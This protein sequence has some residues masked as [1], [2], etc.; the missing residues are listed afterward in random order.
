[1][2]VHPVGVSLGLFLS[3]FPVCYVLNSVVALE[4]PV[5]IMATGFAVLALLF[6]VIYVPSGS[7][8]PLFS[9]FMVFSFTSGI[10]AIIALEE[11]GYVSDFMGFYM[12]EGEPYLTTAHGI[13]MCYWDSV[14]HYTL[15]LAMILAITQR[16]SYRN[17]GL[18]WIGSL[19]MNL[20]VF[21]LGNVIG[22]YGSEIRPAFLLNTPFLVIPIWAATRIFPQPKDLPLVT[23][24]KIAEEQGKSLL[25]RPLD[26]GLVAYLLFAAAFTL[27]RG[28]VVLDCPADAC[29]DYLY[30]Q[31]P[32]LRDPV[33]Y[34]KIQ[35]L[36][37]LHYVLPYFCVCIYGLL[38]PGVTWMPDWALVF[39][40]AIAQAQMSHIGSSLH[41]RTP[42][43][44][45]TPE[46]AW[47]IFVLSNTLYAI[48]PH[49]LA[50]RCLWSPA[51][52]FSSVSRDENKKTQ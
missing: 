46:D 45:R 13:M 35:M 2:R 51:F 31:E 48:G 26:L 14:V 12:R 43:P 16:K 40:G 20:V 11:D 10:D 1:M 9:V 29:F 50:Y 52:F 15:Y 33:A 7:R 44:Y 18:Y 4:H 8:D 30:Q 42:F 25:Q 27:F 22:K 34:P 49:V 47:W 6:A 38:R 32:Y 17:V 19:T 37:Y 24:D 5:A 41:H 28:L 23:A 3:A 39:A 21:L 36:V